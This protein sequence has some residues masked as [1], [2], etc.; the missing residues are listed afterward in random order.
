[1]STFK[2]DNFIRFNSKEDTEPNVS[3]ADEAICKSGALF[4][5]S[6]NKGHMKCVIDNI[7][8]P[9]NNAA[10]ILIA[11]NWWERRNRKKITHFAPE[12][13]MLPEYGVCTTGIYFI[14]E[15]IKDL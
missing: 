9:L 14:F 8:R 10:D 6:E 2:R 3:E 5:T 1:M 12:T 4:T 11:L 15:R 13:G 7:R